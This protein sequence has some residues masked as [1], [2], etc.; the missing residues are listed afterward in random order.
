VLASIYRVLKLG[1][2]F[3]CLA[4]RADYVWHRTMAPPVGVCHQASFQ[5][6]NTDSRRIFR[7][8]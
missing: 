6:P 4:P 5:R 7:A 1:G 2:R 8:A 3:F